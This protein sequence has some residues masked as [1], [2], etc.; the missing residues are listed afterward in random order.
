M[1]LARLIIDLAGEALYSLFSFETSRMSPR[2]EATPPRPVPDGWPPFYCRA[3]EAD[4]RWIVRVKCA[5]TGRIVST[6]LP[7]WS[8]EEECRRDAWERHADDPRPE[9]ADP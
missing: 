7:R 2:P 9:L 6:S 4:D 3:R 5:V 8:T 1:S